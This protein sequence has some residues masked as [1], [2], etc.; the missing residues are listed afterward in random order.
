M[1]EKIKK[2]V[3]WIPT[4]PKTV[5]MAM[6]L[7]I[8]VSLA[9]FALRTGKPKEK[10]RDKLAKNMHLENGFK[11]GLGVGALIE[12]TSKLKETYRMK[13]S[14]DSLLSKESLTT[15]DS[16]LLMQNLQRLKT[17]A[18]SKFE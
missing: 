15:E 11:D 10:G 17:V 2:L 3:S 13:N 5:F 8:V 4:N 7:L 18:Q 6:V 16:V 12:E 14:I 9:N 1:N